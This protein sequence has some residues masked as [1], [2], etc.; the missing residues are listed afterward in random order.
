MIIELHSALNQIYQPDVNDHNYHHQICTSG[1]DDA[2]PRDFLKML[3]SAHNEI[4]SVQD[5]VA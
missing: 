3:R 2:M 1:R 4:L 5:A